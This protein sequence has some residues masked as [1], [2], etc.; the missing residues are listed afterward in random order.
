MKSNTEW[1]YWGEHDPL[2]GVASWS[3]RAKDG[4]NPWNDSEFYLLG[5][6]DWADI[7]AH[8]ERYG[9]RAGRCVEIGCGAG[10][11]TRAMAPYFGA[12]DA[13]DVSAD[14]IRYAQRNIAHK[15]VSFHLVEH[16]RIPLADHSVDAVLSTHVFQHFERR[17]DAEAYFAE[18]ARVL[19]PGGNMMI[20]LPLHA[21]PA[22]VGTLT[23][24]AHAGNLLLARVRAGAKRAAIRR[25]FGARLMRFNSYDLD[26]LHGYLA[27]LGFCN[28]E[29]AIFTMRSN[30]APHGFV[31]AGIP[32]GN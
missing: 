16:A 31:L 5:E 12:V 3:G 29:I 9:L 21:W 28:V 10:R 17:A 2:F 20:H 8:W 7:R 1:K 24:L 11:L 18:I 19:S 26:W 6:S 30:G 22:G 25:G 13:L 4:P 23:R 27:G 32:G 15:N 14:M